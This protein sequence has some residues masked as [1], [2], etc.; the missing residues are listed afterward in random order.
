MDWVNTHSTIDG[1]LDYFQLELFIKS[2]SAAVN[3]CVGIISR[4]GVTVMGIFIFSKY[5]QMAI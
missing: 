5:C 3:L 2:E 4:S 1:H